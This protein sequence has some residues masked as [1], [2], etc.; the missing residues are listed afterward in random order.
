MISLS[1]RYIETVDDPNRREYGP[2]LREDDPKLGEE[3]KLTE[4]EPNIREDN[5]LMKKLNE[6]KSTFRF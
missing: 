1:S 3:E 6:E 5:F 4:D 2:K